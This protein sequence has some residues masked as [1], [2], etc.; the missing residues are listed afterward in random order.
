M[1]DKISHYA[2]FGRD[3]N[4]ARSPG[5]EKPHAVK[6]RGRQQGPALVRDM[7]GSS[8]R[9]DRLRSLEARL[10]DLPAVDRDRVASLRARIESG[11]YEV[12]ADRLARKLL[13]LEQELG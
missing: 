3:N 10:K 4:S 5:P 13:R 2:R 1:A 8:G 12:N 9:A 7:A 6:Q 11:D